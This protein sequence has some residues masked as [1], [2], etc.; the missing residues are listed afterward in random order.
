M[1][2]HT[3]GVEGFVASNFEVHVTK[4]APHRALKLVV[5]GQ[6]GFD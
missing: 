2:G 4:F 5:R 1:S 6:L 3:G